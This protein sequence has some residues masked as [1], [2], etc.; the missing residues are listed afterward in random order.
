M[1][2]NNSS[3][4]TSYEI[5]LLLDLRKMRSEELHAGLVKE[6]TQ[7]RQLLSKIVCYI[8]EV[9][10]RKL[11]LNFKC[12]NLFD[13]LTRNMKYSAGSAQRRLDAARLLGEAPELAA[14]LA[15]GELTLNQVSMVAQGLK[16]ARREA[17]S[18][19]EKFTSTAEVKRDLLEK[20]K[21]QPNSQAQQVVAQTLNLEI[22]AFEKKVI[23]RD[24]SLRLEITFSKEEAELLKEV[25]DLLSHVMPG[26]SYKEVLVESLKEVKKKRVAVVKLKPKLEKVTSTLKVTA[27]KITEV[28]KPSAAEVR[29]S[30]FRKDKSCR[31]K[32]DNGKV[33]GSTFQLQID[34][35]RSQWLGG[36]DEKE[37]LQVLCSAHNRLKYQM[38]IGLR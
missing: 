32:F 11:Y 37:N 30:V 31:W 8:Y 21:A 2:I 28:K 18:K 14:D 9:D 20:V 4:L 6:T 38:E 34:H 36:R 16:Q 17:V 15:S 25:R 13:Y 22:K 19:G 1:E 10:R 3:L 23:Q 26:A 5:N 12:A 7:E 33:C 29:R 24:E 27:P 35:K